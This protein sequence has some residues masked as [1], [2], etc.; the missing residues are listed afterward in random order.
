MRLILVPAKFAILAAAFCLT[1]SGCGGGGDMTPQGPELG[2]VQ[3]YLADNPDAL[4]DDDIA[5]E[6]EEG[7]AAEEE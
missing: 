3:Q 4:V 6:D 5:T 2:E 7:A 1:L